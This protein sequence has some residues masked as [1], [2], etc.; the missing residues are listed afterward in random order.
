MIVFLFLRKKKT[1]YINYFVFSFFKGQ[2]FCYKIIVSFNYSSVYKLYE[3][4]RDEVSMS[5][6]LIQDP[7][8]AVISLTKF[9]DSSSIEAVVKNRPPNTQLIK[10]GKYEFYKR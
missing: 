1:F 9:N 4:A 8:Q 7:F 10:I 3:Q 6:Y 5:L 2:I